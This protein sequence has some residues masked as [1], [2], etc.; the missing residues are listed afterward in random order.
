[1]KKVLLNNF[2]YIILVF[3]F[4][5]GIGTFLVQESFAIVEEMLQV[6]DDGGGGGGSYTPP[7]PPPTPIT[8]TVLANGKTSETV[9]SGDNKVTISWG[10]TGA[11]SCSE[12]KGR[13]GTGETGFFDVYNLTATTIFTVTCKT[14]AYCSGSYTIKAT[15]DGACRKY[16]YRCGTDGRDFCYLS[17]TDDVAWVEGLIYTDTNNFCVYCSDAGNIGYRVNGSSWYQPTCVE[18][19]WLWCTGSR[20]SDSAAFVSSAYATKSCSG[21][22]E[23]DCR[24]RSPVSCTW[25]P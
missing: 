6:D 5:I 16:G 24:A 3:V 20:W 23:H 12:S 1:M 25:N 11:T 8:V 10:S 9:K 22:S 21:L 13:G 14:L 18:T 15:P 2:K 4:I 17:C 19:G 7:P